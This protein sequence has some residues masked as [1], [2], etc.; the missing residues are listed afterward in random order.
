PP[1]R[2]AV[3]GRGTEAFLR[4]L[5]EQG[6]GLRLEGRVGESER[7]ADHA[8]AAA[9][10]VLEVED[11]ASLAEMRIGEDLGG[12]E[13]GAARDPA[14]GEGAHDLV[15]VVLG[16]PALDDGGE[17]LD[18][19][20]PRRRRGEAGGGAGGG[21]ARDPGWGLEGVGALRAGRG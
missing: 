21:T 3:A 9:R 15:L 16:R 5:A 13:H 10:W 1:V 7:T 18:V 11:R 2:R 8:E 17:V 14:A 20:G 4:V 6:R 19:L 12:V